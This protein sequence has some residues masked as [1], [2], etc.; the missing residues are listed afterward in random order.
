MNML[1]PLV[2]AAVLS[3][4]ALVGAC[5][6][7]ETSGNTNTGG[8]GGGSSSGDGGGSSS[9]DAGSDAPSAATCATNGATG[10]VGGNHGTNPHPAVDIPGADFATP[11]NKTYT[12]AAGGGNNHTHTVDLTAAELTMLKGGTSVMKTSSAP[13]VGGGGGGGAA[14]HSITFTC[15]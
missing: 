2:I 4:T 11:A 15:K 9:G 5:S 8:D 13:S 1:R 14:P 10:A 6:S 7:D 3:V 12:L